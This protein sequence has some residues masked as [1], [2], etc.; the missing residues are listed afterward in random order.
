MFVSIPEE[1]AHCLLYEWVNYDVTS[2]SEVTAYLSPHVG[3]A[4]IKKQNFSFKRMENE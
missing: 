3:N 2:A 4:V 1:T